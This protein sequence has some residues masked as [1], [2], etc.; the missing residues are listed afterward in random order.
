MCQDHDQLIARFFG[1][2][3]PDWQTADGRQVEALLQEILSTLASVYRYPLGYDE[4]QELEQQ[5]RVKLMVKN[6]ESIRARNVKELRGYCRRTLRT[7]F[8]DMKKK[9]GRTIRL[10]PDQEGAERQILAREVGPETTVGSVDLID[11]IMECI[12]RSN[13]RSYRFLEM[14]LSRL[15]P[16][17]ICAALDVTEANLYQVR[18][19]TRQL[20]K[21]CADRVSEMPGT[22]RHGG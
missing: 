21:E 3:K 10:E 13:M 11:K 22:N 7:T 18:R 9:A 14:E 17:E 2:E 6:L 8:L 1:A 15:T 4:L 12:R 16:Q 5:V 20:F 19:R